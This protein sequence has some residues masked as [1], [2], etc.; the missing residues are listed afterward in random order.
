RGNRRV[1]PRPS[2]E[3]SA[4]EG[5]KGGGVKFGGIPAGQAAGAILAHSLRV[6]DTTFKK[7]RLL[8]EADIAALVQ[9]GF[10]TIVAVRL[11]DGDLDENEAADRI[12]RAVAGENVSLSAART[13]R[14]N[15]AATARGLAMLDPSRVDRLN[16]VDESLTLA[17][18][19][20]YTP[21]EA[22]ELVATGQILAI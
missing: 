4:R 13:G 2:D 8:S 6:G 12:A 11:G 16:L 15:I 17:T 14:C 20:P 5:A 21:V 3:R 9:A 7:G 18:V 19:L 22:G 1:D 10:E